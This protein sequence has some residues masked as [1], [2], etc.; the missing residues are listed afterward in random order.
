MLSCRRRLS[1]WTGI[2]GPAYLELGVEG[3]PSS[4]LQGLPEHRMIQGQVNLPGG[5]RLL[6]P[7]CKCTPQGAGAMHQRAGQVQS[8]LQGGVLGVL[9]P[10][11]PGAQKEPAAAPRLEGG[12]QPAPEEANTPGR[13]A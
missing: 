7:C 13:Q 6:P 3:D 9:L 1:H 5:V 2:Q 4:E 10:G 11:A 12:H 8:S